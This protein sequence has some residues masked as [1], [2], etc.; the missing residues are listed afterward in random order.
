MARLGRRS[1][2]LWYNPR[3]LVFVTGNM[4]EEEEPEQRSPGRRKIEGEI[5]LWFGTHDNAGYKAMQEQ[6]R[7]SKQ[8]PQSRHVTPI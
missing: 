1:G 5:R 2:S 7:T 4:E 8:S 3:S 6:G